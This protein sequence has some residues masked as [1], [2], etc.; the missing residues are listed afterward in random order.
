MESRD[1]KCTNSERTTASQVLADAMS[2]GQLSVTEF[3]ER[4]SR[5]AEATTR[6]ELVDLVADLIEAPEQVLFGSHQVARQRSKEVKTVNQGAVTAVDQALD[7]V[8]PSAQGAQGLSPGI[9][10]GST[11][12]GIPI[13]A[14]HTTMG[15]F[16]GT[17]VDLRGASLK[18]HV[19]TIQAVG[20]FG[21]VDVW[22][23]EGFRVR[24]NGVGLFGGHDIKVER[25]A[26]DPADL[27]ASAPEV[28]VNCFSL[29]GGV[30]VH[31]VKR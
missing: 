15:I 19:T 14:H 22:V 17:D 9:F 5:C 29:F 24:V 12:R 2:V 1:I 23:P 21:G 4:S 11:V 16:G 31:V 6:G 3:E 27:P 20:V 7:Q 18:E 30:D 13:A 8:E 28:V 10:G 25:G 26:I